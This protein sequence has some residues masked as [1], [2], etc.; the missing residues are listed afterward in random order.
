MNPNPTIFEIRR[1]SDVNRYGVNRRTI[2]LLYGERNAE[3]VAHSLPLQFLVRV[4]VGRQQFFP[5]IVP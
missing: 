4:K 3:E 5:K 2:Y 1:D